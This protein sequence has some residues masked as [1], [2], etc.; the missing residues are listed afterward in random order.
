MKKNFE[1]KIII[2]DFGSQ[3]TQLIARRVR[4]IGVYCEVIYW[5][6]VNIVNIFSVSKPKGVILSGGPNSV[7]KKNSPKI[8][9]FIFC[10]DI[11]VLGICYGMQAMIYQLGGKVKKSR[12]R[13]FGFTK[14][15]IIKKNKLTK[16]I[17]DYI[18]SKKEHILNVWSS[19]TDVVCKLPEGFLNVAITKSCT[20]IVVND[21]RKLYGL[22]FHPEVT[23]TKQGK[24]IIKRF[25]IGIC[26]CKNDW[27]TSNIID[28]KIEYIRKKI[29]NERVILGF[30]GGI[31]S[32]VSA[33]LLKKAVNKQLI[34]I[35]LDNGFLDSKEYKKNIKYL[36]KKFN[37]KVIYVSSK[38]IFFSAISGISNPEKKRKV[39][40]KTFIKIFRKYSKYYKAKFFAQGTVYSDVIESKK[41]KS[42]NIK[43][44]KSHHNVG[45]LPKRI[46]LNIL[47]PLKD[48]FKDEV[49][50][51][52]IK[53]GISGE[54]LNKYPFPGPGFC[55]RI[56]GKV[57]KKYCKILCKSDKIFVQELKKANIYNKISQ[58]FT[59]FVPIKSVSILGDCR[60]YSWII[61]L[62]AVKTTDFMTAKWVYIPH[63]IL[64]KISCRMINEI[65]N[66]SRVVYDISGKPPSTIE[67]E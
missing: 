62:R 21:K 39:V 59:I 3:Y 55:I 32:L 64:E 1:H 65:D 30:S 26:K 37:L 43:Y 17:Y 48:L 49:K 9:E 12:K 31:D 40:G 50:K 51:I 6:T 41:N 8:P 24:N 11:P 5:N 53:L 44:I 61:V 19:H 2:I 20:S 36:N 63:K 29:K 33:I 16:N 10:Y 45:G 13:E 28:K 57:K 14:V 67:W 52:G 34:C 27:I 46:K 4:E 47:E 66:I 60:K 38:K 18:N 35:F 7:T 54:I 25:V 42:S 22:Q 58:A 56:I 23:Q 15:K